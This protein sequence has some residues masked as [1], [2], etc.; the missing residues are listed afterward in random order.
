MITPWLL[1]LA[2][3]S[4]VLSYRSRKPERQLDYALL[5]IAATFLGLLGMG[6][7]VVIG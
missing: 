7:E 1:P 6:L 5:G 4:F 2:A 3:L